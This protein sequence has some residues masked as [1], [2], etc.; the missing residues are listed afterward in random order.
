MAEDARDPEGSGLTEEERAMARQAGLTEEEWAA[1]KEK[2]NRPETLISM[3]KTQK[4][5]IISDI[6][7]LPAGPEVQKVLFQIQNLLVPFLPSEYPDDKD[8]LD[9]LKI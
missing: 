6:E 8:E 1:A 7:G 3:I 5:L 2:S 4:T 9:E